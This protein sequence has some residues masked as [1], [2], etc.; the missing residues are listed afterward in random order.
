MKSIDVN[1][2]PLGMSRQSIG[3]YAVG[4]FAI[5]VGMS[6][7]QWQKYLLIGAG[8]ILLVY[9]IILLIEPLKKGL[10]DKIPGTV[11]MVFI[12]ISLSIC[13][14]QLIIN[15]ATYGALFFALALVYFAIFIFVNVYKAK[16]VFQNRSL[17]VTLVIFLTSYACI[18]YFLFDRSSP[19]YRFG[20]VFTLILWLISLGLLVKNILGTR[21]NRAK[22]KNA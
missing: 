16:F 1:K 18:Q 2:T 14:V 5:N 4:L 12:V 8:I 20:L 7:Q 9:G 15:G 22:I 10:T 17:L 13:G 3:Y 21:K 6:S 19:A 11:R